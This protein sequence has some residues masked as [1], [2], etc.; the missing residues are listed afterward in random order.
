MAI[1]QYP[2]WLRQCEPTSRNEVT[3][4]LSEVSENGVVRGRVMHTHSTYEL[5]LSHMAITRDE[6]EQWEQWWETNYN[7]VVVVTWVPD[8]VDYEGVFRESPRVAY[9]PFQ[10][11]DLEVTL[12]VKKAAYWP[13]VAVAGT[14]GWFEPAPPKNFNDLQAAG[15]MGNTAAWVTGEYVVLLDNS[16]AYWDGT[17]WVVGRAP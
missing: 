6:F 12:L 11:F 15:P 14:P 3:R 8:G 4:V 1:V 2:D 13:T 9:A 5:Q 17:Q 16:E 7:N 10:R